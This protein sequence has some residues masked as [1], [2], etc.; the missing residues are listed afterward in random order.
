ML[1]DEDMY[2]RMKKG[3]RGGRSNCT[4]CGQGS[5][6]KNTRIIS[7]WL[8]DMCKLLDIQSVCDAGAGDLH[9]I[10]H[11]KWDVDF[12]AFDLIPRHHNV[13]KLDITREALPK[14]DAI[15]CRMVLN[16]LDDERIKMA[17]ELFRG[18]A[19]YLFATQFVQ[20]GAQ[21]TREFT[22]LDLTKYLGEPIEMCTDGHEDN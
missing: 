12:K 22:R 16:H 17:L 3:W 14:C 15:I 19:K 18:S 2:N 1:S 11:L 13:E 7:E 20:G 5:T 8:P 9:W 6:I 10:K 4:D 21:R